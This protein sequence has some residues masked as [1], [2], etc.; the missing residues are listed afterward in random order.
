MFRYLARGGQIRAGDLR[1]LAEMASR[2]QPAIGSDAV[3]GVG[4]FASAQ[5]PG[6]LFLAKVTAVSGTGSSAVY[7]VT[8]HHVVP[9]T[10][11]TQARVSGRKGSVTVNLARYAGSTTLAVD[12]LVQVRR[13]VAAVNEWEIIGLVGSSAAAFSGAA[14]LHTGSTLVIANNTLTTISFDVSEE[15]DTDN[16]HD[17]VVNPSRFTIPS[18]GYYMYGAFVDWG[19]GP[20][21]KRDIYLY[22]NGVQSSGDTARAVPTGGVLQTTSSMYSLLAGDYIELKVLQDNGGNVNIFSGGARFW[23]YRVG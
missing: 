4:G 5:P 2:A 19:T 23:I 14:A 21:N 17:L 20:N 15:F 12:D 10:G 11:G 6:D 1:Q 7:A 22:K 8:E 18:A 3:S 9:N 13:N 16:Y